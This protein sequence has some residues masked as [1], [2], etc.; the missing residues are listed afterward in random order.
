MEKLYFMSVIDENSLSQLETYGMY[1]YDFETQKYIKTFKH[2]NEVYLNAM[3]E[4]Y[5]NYEIKWV[6]HNE[7]AYLTILIDLEELNKINKTID[8]MEILKS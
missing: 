4:F 1:F 3:K 6:N 7:F 5:P 2:P 8:T